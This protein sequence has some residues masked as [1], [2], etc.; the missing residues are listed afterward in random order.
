MNPFIKPDG[1]V[2]RCLDFEAYRFNEK[3]NQDRVKRHKINLLL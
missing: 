2:S 3:I 1:V